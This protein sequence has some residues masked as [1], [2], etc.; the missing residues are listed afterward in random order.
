MIPLTHHDIVRLSSPFT[1]HGLRVDLAATDR[2]GRLIRFRS[3]RVVGPDDAAC[4]VHHELSAA[5][6]RELHVRRAVWH[7]AALASVMHASGSDGQ[8]LADALDALP[9]TDQVFTVDGAPCT[10]SVRL[11]LPGTADSDSV[12]IE[13]THLSARVR[14]LVLSVDVSTG[15]G[16]PA[17]VTLALVGSAV[18]RP[19]AGRANRQRN[20]LASGDWLPAFDPLLRACHD[21]SVPEPSLPDV[22]DDVLAILGNQWRPLRP[23]G[24]HFRTVLRQLGRPPRRAELADGHFRSAV[25]HL[26]GVLATPAQSYH[27][28]FQR[29][30]RAV[31][32]RRLRPVLLLLGIFALMPIL[33]VAVVHGG[34]TLHPLMLGLTPLLMVAAIA[35]SV[36][37]IP[38]M[39]W[40]DWPSPLTDDALRRASGPTTTGT[41]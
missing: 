25:S 29:Q 3:Q 14:Q 30:R 27:A 17:D 6:K 12:E 15:G 18:N 41:T 2:G 39:E 34:M 33:Y 35:L 22:P 9:V 13:L 26:H 24:D 5:S 21:S 40:P 7:P 16:M 28:R 11:W 4:L 19:L 32:L 23:R 20:S 38:V 31:Y 8:R 10:R 37:E 1:R 36:R